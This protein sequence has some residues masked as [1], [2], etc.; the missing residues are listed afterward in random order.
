V[1]AILCGAPPTVDAQDPIPRLSNGKPDFTGNWDHS[2]AGNLSNDSEGCGG[3]SAAAGLDLTGSP[4]CTQTGAGPLPYT[5]AGRA[6][7]AANREFD[8]G[9][10]CFPWG[11]VR[12]FGTPFPHAYVHHPDRIAIFFEQDN[13]FKMVPT[14]GRALSDNPDPTWRGTSI[15]Y[16][17][18]ETLVIESIGFNGRSWLDSTRNPNSDQLTVTERMSFIDADHIRW[19]VTITDP[20]N[21]SRPFSNERT[22]LRMEPGDELYEY[23]C[24]ENN[25]CSGGECTPADVQLGQ[26]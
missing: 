1:F 8:Q 14:D 6:A 10:N 26:P 2:R 3:V 25:R 13:A 19:E 16:W 20:V 5:E 24:S 12:L 23:I 21:Y 4:D 18:D 11:Y 22:F 9:D 15:G 7:R 17:E